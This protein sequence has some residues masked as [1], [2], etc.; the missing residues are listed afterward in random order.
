MCVPLGNS[1]RCIFKSVTKAQR[2]FDDEARS[3]IWS[4]NLGY[5]LVYIVKR[6]C[7]SRSLAGGRSSRLGSRQRNIIS[8]TAGEM[9]SGIG[10]G[11][12]DDA[13]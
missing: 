12:L 11:L 8:F 7:L 13:I 10:G 5:R 9:F 1:L 2:L 4:S 3:V 6:G